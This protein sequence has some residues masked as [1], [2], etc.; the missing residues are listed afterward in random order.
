MSDDIVVSGGGSIAVASDELLWHAEQLR[1]LT[2]EMREA[3]A[4][5]TVIDARVDGRSVA[6]AASVEEARRAEDAI[7]SALRQFERV[8]VGAGELSRSLLSSAEAY[9]AAELVATAASEL[10]AG[11]IADILGMF[12]PLVLLWLLPALSTTVTGLLIG[13]LLAPGGPKALIDRLPTM[14]KENS[15]LVSN[16][17]VVALMR[18]AASTSDDAVNGRLGI[19]PAISALLGDRGLGLTG[20]DTTAALLTGLGGGVGLLAESPVRAARTGEVPVRQA[21]SGMAER[22]DRV[23]EPESNGGSQVRI[24]RY[25]AEGQ[26]D[27]FEVYI[28]GTV[29]FSPVAGDEPWDM[30]SNIAGVG[31]LP[32]GSYRAVVEALAEAGVTAESPVQF[33]GY[34]QGGLVAAMLAASGDYD[35]RGLVTFGAPA[36]NVELPGTFPVIAVEHAEDI[37]PATGGDQVNPSVVVAR[38]EL[39]ADAEVPTDMVFPAHQRPSYAS[40]AALLDEQHSPALTSAMQSIASFAAGATAAEGTMYS[41]VRVAPVVASGGAGV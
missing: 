32:A 17:V 23:P 13:S 40:T 4:R 28:A 9:G 24:E 41:A 36:G 33:T 6:R 8:G 31:G 2:L 39:Y 5:L 3:I 10:V 20:V 18:M 35:T 29:D 27:R 22:F 25:S 21:P 34:S 14:L 19:P 7:D 16:P 15:A 30:T 26:P 11:A 38:R 37:V 1:V 12:F